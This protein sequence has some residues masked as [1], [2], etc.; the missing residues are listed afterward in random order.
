M[1]VNSKEAL[2]L[3]RRHH[4]AGQLGEAEKVYR[5]VLQEQPNHPEA[6]HLLGALVGQRGDIESAIDLIRRSIALNGHDAEAHRN[7][8]VL[9]AKQGRFEEA[10]VALSRTVQLQPDD[11]HAHHN[12]AKVLTAQGKWD[13]ALAAYR[14]V[15]QLKPNFAQV[16][17]DVGY[18]LGRQAR[19]EEAIA[20][21]STAI[22]L[23]PNLA[24]AHFGLGNVYRAT[25]HS[26]EALASYREAVRIM[27]D[28]L[29]AYT[30]MAILLAK[31]HQ[32]EEAMACHV[33]AVQLKP[34]SALA[35][36]ALGW[37]ML[38]RNGAASAIDRFRRAV[39]TDPN[40]MGAW[41]SLGLA[42]QY[43][44]RFEEAAECFRH[45]LSVRPDSAIAHKE[46]L[47][48][49][50]ETSDTQIEPLKNL[51]LQP[52][53]SISERISG[54]FALGTALD[55]A[56]RF[57]EAF[58]HFALANTLEKQQRASIGETYDA[59]GFHARVNRLIE[60]FTPEFF[61]HHRSWGDPLE[62][63]VFVVGMP[64]SGTTLAQQIAASHP[65]VYGAGELSGIFQISKTLDSTDAAQWN[66]DSVKEAANQHRDYLRRLNDRASRII[67]KMPANLYYLGLIAVLFPRAR[68]ILCRR[69]ARDTCLSCYFQSFSGGNI[70]S[71]DL[72]NCG[73][74]HRENDRLADHWRRVLPM[75]M[76]EFTYEEVVADLEGQSRRLIDFL[77]VPWD[78]ACLEFYRTK[79]TVLTSSVWQVRQPIYQSSVGR[80]RHYERHLGSLLKAL[81]NP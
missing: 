65:Q 62:L 68:V 58:S 42:L 77:G 27:P 12:L 33:R 74:H 11:L 2:N 13:D 5:R 28:L 76:L 17:N 38:H 9:M 7:L 44:G 71:Y 15:I 46:L 53:L 69:D 16:H 22:L 32:F 23:Q 19:Y 14:R 34:N 10:F 79:T 39:A 81:G 29:E 54:E 55:R 51:L 56:Q 25:G 72:A 63:P 24:L 43:G 45:I 75:A 41:N 66:A 49:S 50:K 37:I 60:V 61:K 4:R 67:D 31:E 48:G 47:D 70:F 3:A 59:N 26:K 80:W 73:H 36:E 40:L 64:R 6:L 21:F 18:I 20:A 78:P 30:S 57:D 8:G 1:P 35:D 52:N